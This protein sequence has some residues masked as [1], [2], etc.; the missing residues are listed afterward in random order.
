[1]KTTLLM[2]VLMLFCAD[3]FAVVNPEVEKNALR[4]KSTVVISFQVLNVRH[5]Q[6]GDILYTHADVAVLEVI[7]GDFVAESGKAVVKV[8]Y[9]ANYVE[10]RRQLDEMRDNKIVGGITSSQA[11]TLRVGQIATGWFKPG[12]RGTSLIPAAGFYS[13]ENE[14]MPETVDGALGEDLILPKGTTVIIRDL[15]M[16]LWLDRFTFVSTCPKSATC[17]IGGFWRPVVSII[18]GGRY[19]ELLLH[20]GIASRLERQEVQIELV[21]TDARTHATIKL[22]RL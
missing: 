11:P 20:Q 13:F 22:S 16:R 17:V 3:A 18:S 1:M 2:I 7:R 19:S 21:E 6:Q 10:A 8:S 9:G 5:E 4:S 12:P 15:E 14:S